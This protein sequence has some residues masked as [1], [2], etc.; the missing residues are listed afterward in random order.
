LS[1]SRFQARRFAKS[2]QIDKIWS[3][4]VEKLERFTAIK[5]TK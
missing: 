4:F 5:N 2:G 1:A 3:N